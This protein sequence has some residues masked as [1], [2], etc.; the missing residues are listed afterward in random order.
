MR[1]YDEVTKKPKGKLE[2]TLNSPGHSN[3]IFSI[4]FNKAD[5]TILASAGWDKNVI[6]W[7]LVGMR[8]VSQSSAG[9]QDQVRRTLHLRGQHRPLWEPFGHGVLAH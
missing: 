5:P 9:A 2:G 8:A 6:I 1:L 4:K 3:R 7:D